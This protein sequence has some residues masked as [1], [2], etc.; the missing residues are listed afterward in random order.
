M[1]STRVGVSAKQIQRETGVTYKTAWRMMKQVRTLMGDDD[2]LSGP[3]EIDET[4]FGGLEGNKHKHLRGGAKTIAF[5]AVERGGRVTTAVISDANR[6]TVFPLV[7]EIIPPNSTI[8]TDG[9]PMYKTLSPN[10][11][12]PARRMESMRVPSAPVRSGP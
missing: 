3:F 5:G 4:E 7:A 8:Y 11:A 1:S 6:K 10:S 12:I 2:E 9:A